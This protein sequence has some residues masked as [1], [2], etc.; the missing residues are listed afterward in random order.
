MRF[1]I[2]VSL[3]T[4]VLLASNVSAHGVVTKVQDSNKVDGVALG[5]ADPTGKKIRLF[6]QAH[7][8]LDVT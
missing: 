7:I 8:S 6:N 5:V 2:P 3:F 4:T 1:T